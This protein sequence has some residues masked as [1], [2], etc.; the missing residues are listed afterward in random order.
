MAWFGVLNWTYLQRAVSVMVSVM[1]SI[2][3]SVMVSVMASFMG[4]IIV[5][6]C[7]QVLNALSGRAVY[8]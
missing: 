2:M 4:S 8:K 7:Q 3:V 5:R 1:V 6:V